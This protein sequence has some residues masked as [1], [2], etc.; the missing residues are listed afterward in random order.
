MGRWFVV[1]SGGN[2]Y[3]YIY[4][5]E[6]TVNNKVYIGQTKDP[7]KRRR[8]HFRRLKNN[9]HENPYLQVAWNKYGEN[10]FTFEVIDEGENYNQ[11]EKYYIKKY[12]SND[13]NY[14]YNILPGGEEPPIWKGESSYK[15][16]LTQKQVD[17]IKQMLIKRVPK[18]EILKRIDNVV[19]MGQLRRINNGEAW[20]D[21]KLTYPLSGSGTYEMFIPPEKVDAIIIELQTT[22]KTQK[23]IANKYEVARSSV[24]AINNGEHTNLIRDNIEYPIRKKNI[25]NKE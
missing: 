24:T 11:L 9:K 6:N 20:H 16:K 18:K 14:G 23:E 1:G 19:T 22:N 7:N 17:E 10:N 5:I 25:K 8:D 21:D 2:L 12:K 4:K 3:K 15:A 13:N